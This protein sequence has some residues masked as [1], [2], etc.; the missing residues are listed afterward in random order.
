[1]TDIYALP[2]TTGCISGL[3]D[4]SVSGVSLLSHGG[5]KRAAGAWLSSSRLVANCRPA[6]CLS[7]QNRNPWHTAESALEM[8]H[9]AGVYWRGNQRNDRRDAGRTRA[10]AVAVVEEGLEQAKLELLSEVLE[11]GRGLSTTADQR[12]IVEEKLVAVEKF[13]AGT[14][15]EL[16]ELDG[17]WLLQYT[18]APDVVQILQASETP[19]L[20]VGQIF[21]KFECKERADDGV[22]RNVVRLSVPGILQ[23]DGAT[24]VVTAEFSVV[25]SRSIALNFEEAQLGQVEISAGLQA[26]LA[27]A[28]LPRT[29][30][31]LEVLQFFRNLIVRV[32]LV[33]SVIRNNTTKRAPV[34]LWYY[35]TYLDRDM[36]VGRAL[37]SGGVFVFCRTQQLELP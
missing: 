24:L 17:T 33:Q 25:S 4:Q 36:L 35:L 30:L 28:F 11:T 19:F 8:A 13:D 1:M 21:Q 5:S 37:G 20:Q 16:D 2:A 34:G 10:L 14:P 22:V 3:W 32:P 18:T 29:F 27:P 12:A 15:L 26:L 23:D 6:L 31:N 7:A 9:R